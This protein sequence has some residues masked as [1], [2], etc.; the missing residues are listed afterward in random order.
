MFFKYL[1]NYLQGFGKHVLWFFDSRIA[2]QQF[3]IV[4]VEAYVHSCHHADPYAHGDEGSFG[5]IFGAKKHVF[6]F[7]PAYFLDGWMDGWIHDLIFWGKQLV[8]TGTS[9]RRVGHTKVE[10]SKEWI[11][12]VVTK[13]PMSLL[14]FFFVQSSIPQRNSSKGLV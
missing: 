14:V 12:H 11:W 6:F 5:F 4:E 3:R 1:I 2:G 13:N 9:T 8:E 10:V 7:W